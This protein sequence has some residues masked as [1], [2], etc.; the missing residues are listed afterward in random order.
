M[1]FIFANTEHLFYNGIQTY[2]SFYRQPFASF[3]AFH[4]K[5]LILKKE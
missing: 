3:K 1:Q 4:I 5:N 2:Y